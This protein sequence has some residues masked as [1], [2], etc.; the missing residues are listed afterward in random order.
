MQ[1][2]AITAN[3]NSNIPLKA[4]YSPTHNIQTD[5]KKLEATCGYEAKNVSP[6][7]NFI[8]HYTVSEKD[9]GLNLMC[10]KKPGEDGYFMLLVSPGQLEA[11]A[12]EKDVVFVMDT[13]G[14]MNGSKIEQAK[15]ALNFCLNGMA[16]KDRF[17]IITFAT[18]MDYYAD[19]LV[20]AEQKNILAAREF[21]SNIA[22]SGG[23]NINQAVLKAIGMFGDTK[24]PRMLVF[25]TDGE[26]TEGVTDIKEILKNV[27]DANLAKT[28]IFVFGVGDDVNANF[29]DRMSEVNRGASEY[30]LQ[31]ENIETKVS[32]FFRK[33]TEPVMADTNINYGGIKTKDVYPLS[34]PDI[35]KGNQLTIMGRYNKESATKI[36][37]KGYV[38][39]EEKEY[40]YEGNFPQEQE[41]YDFIPR[42]WATRKIGH[43]LSEIRFTQENREL[44]DEVIRLSKEFGII[45]P[46]TS[47]LVTEPNGSNPVVP[48]DGMLWANSAVD[49]NTLGGSSG[50]IMDADMQARADMAAYE[51]Y[52]LKS[53]M[54]SGQASAPSFFAKLHNLSSGGRVSAKEAADIGAW[55]TEAIM[56]TVTTAQDRIKYAAGRTFYLQDDGFWVDSKYVKGTKTK[57]IKY[58]GKEYMG[59]INNNPELA[60]VFSLAEKVIVVFKGECYRIVD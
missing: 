27:T 41:K 42:L 8:L 32:A 49:N 45:T 43:L 6:D 28:R 15:N 34:L 26:P 39:G 24:R 46:Y 36:I 12:T 18:S 54:P 37:L 7:K 59:L 57:D 47:F 21:V 53:N 55:K 40:V 3:I 60:K 29:L 5:I 25:L 48:A 10:Y 38:N 51:P 16:E 4:V 50:N 1:E 22:A 2:V 14:S 31:D 9:V 35:F 52:Y 23:T 58:L 11:K 17:N 56:D 44:I 33:V 20:G 19:N 30:V 13:S